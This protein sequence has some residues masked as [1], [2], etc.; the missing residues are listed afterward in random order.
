MAKIRQRNRKKRAGRPL[1]AYQKN[2]RNSDRVECRGDFKLGGGIKL[3][4]IEAKVTANMFLRA[5][6][7][8]STKAAQTMSYGIYRTLVKENNSTAAFWWADTDKK[9]KEQ[10]DIGQNQQA[11][12]WAAYMEEKLFAGDENEGATV[13]IGMGGALGADASLSP[14]LGVSAA[15]GYAHFSRYKKDQMGKYLGQSPASKEDAKKRI[16][17]IKGKHMNAAS[18]SLTGKLGKVANAGVKGSL[19]WA[20]REIKTW[21]IQLLTN[22][23]LGQPGDP[24]RRVADLIS[25]IQEFV[26]MHQ[27]VV[28][29]DDEKNSKRRFVAAQLSGILQYSSGTLNGKMEEQLQKIANFDKKDRGNLV[30]DETLTDIE[31]SSAN[32]TPLIGSKRDL[33]VSLA[34]GLNQGRHT[35]R[36]SASDVSKTSINIGVFSGSLERSK[37]VG[38]F[39]LDLGKS[40]AQKNKEKNEIEKLETEEEKTQRRQKLDEQE[41]QIQKFK[42]VVFN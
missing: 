39:F 40:A 20:D 15:L 42:A 17:G 34:F 32:T 22:I 28:N 31:Y 19:A 26:K 9:L 18:F 11:E 27:T 13:D 36:F 5:A 2:E 23:S 35:F 1:D 29:H 21:E 33:K 6:A 10:T 7:A 12:T 25:A 37:L 41:K 24:K 3:P 14:D 4:G 30:S 38:S 16:K 8:N